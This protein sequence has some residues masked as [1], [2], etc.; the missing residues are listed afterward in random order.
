ME[1]KVVF[2]IS[3]WFLTPLLVFVIN[4]LLR[5][6]ESHL[7]GFLFFILFRYFLLYVFG[8]SLGLLDLRL[9][10]NGLKYQ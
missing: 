4:D 7:S 3:K 5:G 10:Y 2:V 6:K 9:K 8:E 1:R